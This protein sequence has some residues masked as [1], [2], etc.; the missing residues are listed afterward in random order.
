MNV[1][2]FIITVFL[3]CSCSQ[4]STD[5]SKKER[6]KENL[7]EKVFDPEE[8]V[9]KQIKKSDKTIEDN[10]KYLDQKSDIKNN[11]I[12]NFEIGQSHSEARQLVENY[13]RNNEVELVD[14]PENLHYFEFDSI[15]INL[16]S[17]E[18][19]YKITLLHSHNEEIC[20]GSICKGTDFEKVTRLLKLDFIEEEWFRVSGT[21]VYILF[22]W[23][24]EEI[25]PIR[26]R[27]FAVGKDVF[28]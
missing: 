28:W 25:K 16:N 15:W 7:Y 21:N 24:Y 20:L 11:S 6:K 9:L 19:D 3:I 13:T 26:V 22:D 23:D 4:E 5:N 10:L 18:E 17:S 1:Y 2:V 12:L 14:N 27:G 8:Y